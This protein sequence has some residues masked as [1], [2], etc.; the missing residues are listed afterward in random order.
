MDDV[1]IRGRIRVLGG[2]QEREGR[3]GPDVAPALTREVDR[4]TVRQLV[5]GSPAVVE[6]IVPEQV[7]VQILGCDPA[8]EPVDHPLY[9]RVVGVHM[10]YVECAPGPRT[11]ALDLDKVE[12][13]TLGETWIG[14]VPVR[15]HT[16][17][18]ATWPAKTF[19]RSAPETFHRFDTI[20]TLF[21][22]RFTAQG[23]HVFSS[24]RPRFEAGPPLSWASLG[25]ALAPL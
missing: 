8:E 20:E 12:F 10:L 19:S 25:S 7:V 15:D 22:S 23:T 14:T 9:A 24:E 11:V 2:P 6:E 16:A 1:R 4:E 21:P 18:S 17:P 5:E 13:V 3:A